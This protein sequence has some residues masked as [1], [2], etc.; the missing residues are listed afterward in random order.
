MRRAKVDGG[1]VV[2]V[3]LVLTAED[4]PHLKDWALAPDYVGVGYLQSSMGVFSAPV[5]VVT[6]EVIN[7]ER[8]RRILRGFMFAGHLFQSDAGSLQKINGAT[9]GALVAKGS[10][11]DG[12]NVNWAAGGGEFSWI[13]ADNFLVSMSP[14]MV[15]AFGMTALAHIDAHIKAARVLKNSLQPDY[16]DDVHWPSAA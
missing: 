5:V 14:D 8:E 7:A 13:A 16:A 10:G 1:V 15:L 12:A 3:A 2:G 4:A 6:P 11:V 9:T